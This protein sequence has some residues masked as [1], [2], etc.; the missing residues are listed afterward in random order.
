[1]P[2]GR[3]LPDTPTCTLAT[4][5]VGPPDTKTGEARLSPDD[6]DTDTSAALKPVT[7]TAN[8]IDALTQREFV[9]V[10]DSPVRLARASAP[11]GGTYDNDN[12]DTLLL[13]PTAGNTCED[14]TSN[15][16]VTVRGTGGRASVTLTL[17][18]D[19]A[20]EVGSITTVPVPAGVTTKSAAR[21]PVTGTENIASTTNEPNANVVPLGDASDAVGGTNTAVTVVEAALAGTTS[22]DAS[23]TRTDSVVV[24]QRPVTFTVS[25][26]VEP[27]TASDLPTEV[28]PPLVTTKSLERTPVT[29][30]LNTAVNCTT[31][32]VKLAPDAP[33]DDVSVTVG[34]R[35]DTVA[36][37]DDAA[38]AGE[39]TPDALAKPILM[40]AAVR[41]AV[42]VT[43]STYTVL[44]MA[45]N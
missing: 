18:T 36:R 41:P 45:T 17:N 5:T 42:H 1:M 8:T 4:Y 28:H 43:C 7:G 39:M 44:L 26:Y 6:G 13:A 22:P 10:L 23:V 34:G 33:K 3:L 15:V 25:V 35:Y 20:G 12:G 27:A 40:L 24:L 37:P 2:D 38:F 16:T 21:T 11:T 32:D 29:L 31:P 9:V 19:E 14:E 30:L